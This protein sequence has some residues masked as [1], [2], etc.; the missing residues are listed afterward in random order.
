MFCLPTFAP[1]LSLRLLSFRNQA[2]RRNGDVAGAGP[3][4]AAG[5]VALGGQDG[6]VSVWLM[7]GRA[8]PI[9]VF[10]HLF[11]QS[12]ADLAWCP[13]GH[14][15]VACSTDGTIA[16]FQVGA[17]GCFADRIEYVLH[18]WREFVPYP[19]QVR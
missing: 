17:A 8:M 19:V 2:T 4:A 3:R 6:R 18:R 1:F 16:V 12:V 10:E 13:D 11:S 9:A 14:A 15:L 7:G 5:C